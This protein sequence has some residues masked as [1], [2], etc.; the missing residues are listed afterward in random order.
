MFLSM[1]SCSHYLSNSKQ[2]VMPKRV[3]ESTLKEGLGS[4]EAETYG[5]GIK[6]LLVCEERSS[7]RFG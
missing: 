1:F 7:A 2:S 4:G 5:F 6:E 3:Q